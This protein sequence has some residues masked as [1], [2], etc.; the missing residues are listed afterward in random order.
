MKKVLIGGFM[1]LIGF[2]SVILA[3]SF[4]D[5]KNLPFHE[6]AKLLVS[7]MT[8]EE[9]SNQLKNNVGAITRLGVRNYNY[10]NEGIHG[11]A[12]SGEA[13]S[14]P[15]S[16]GLSS[17]WDADL[18][19]RVASAISDEAR[20][21]NN[22]TGKGLTYW[23]PT[24]NLS[25][26]PRWGRDEE[27]YGE[28]P[29]LTGTLAV[30]F[31]KGL[32]GDHE[33]YYKTIATAKH[34]AAN[35]MEHERSSTSSNMDERNLREYYLPAF[36][37]CVKDGNVASIMSAYNALNGIPCIANK[38]LLTKILRDEWG[39]DGFVTS[40]C[41]GV[42][43]LYTDHKYATDAV[44]AITKAIKAGNDMNCNGD[45]AKNV[46]QAINENRLTEADI[47]TALVR[48][49][50]SRFR[51]GEFDDDVPYRN[52][53]ASVLN[54]EQHRQLAIDAAHESIVLLK[55]AETD[56]DN[57]PLLPL[58]PD[59][60]V[61]LIGPFA[62]Y[63]NLGGYSGTPV[64]KTSLYQALANRFGV[65]ISDN[66]LQ[67]EKY[68]EKQGNM[69]AEANGC[70]GN[71]GN[72]KAGDWAKYNSVDLGDGCEILTVMTATANSADKA[73]IMNIYLDNMDGQP[74][75]TVDLPA[76]GGWT[77]YKES[78][79]KLNP[80][81]FKGKHTV[82]FEFLGGG[83]FCSNMD[84]FRFGNIEVEYVKATSFMA[85]DFDG[86]KGNAK[87]E[88]AK[89]DGNIT[90]LGNIK[91]G[92]I[93]WF[94]NVNFSYGFDKL[95]FEFATKN[96]KKNAKI[97]F[98]FDDLDSEPVFTVTD[99]LV[100]CGSSGGWQDYI[101]IYKDLDPEVFKGIHTLYLRFYIE[102][103]TYFGNL[104]QILFYNSEDGDGPV[105]DDNNNDENQRL[106]YARC[107]NVNDD[108]GNDIALAQSLAKK[109]DVVIFTAGTDLSTMNEGHDRTTLKLPGGQ[110][111]VLEAIYE[112]NPN[113]ILVLQS[114]SSHDVTWA[115]EHIPAILSA[116]YAGQ[117]QGEAIADVIYGDFNPSGKLT[118]TWYGKDEDL[119][120]NIDDYDIRSRKLTYMYFDKE[121]LYPF[122]YGLSY[123]SFDYSNL[124]ISQSVIAKDETVTITF[125]VTN[126]GD[127]DGAEVVQL[128]THANS[129]L[130]RPIKELKGYE[131]VE[132]KSGETKSVTMTL[133]HD[134][135]SYFNTATKT[136]DV[137][138]GVVDIMVGASSSDIRL[139]D[140]LNTRF[141][142][143]KTTYESIPQEPSSSV[144]TVLT[145]EKAVTETAIYNI[146]GMKLS[147]K[148]LE[149]VSPGIY[150]VNGKKVTTSAKR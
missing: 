125:D 40:D 135:L 102:D 97:E 110:Q 8:L 27:N 95:E 42:G 35:N 15:I 11:V 33:K 28:D 30:Q 16:K 70:D 99:D 100:F 10:W 141:A 67:F 44:D 140:K 88:D 87:A 47:D 118:S 76:T 38:L 36:E 83:T 92:D 79:F 21:Y 2:S 138:E 105:V 115:N 108:R 126:T 117:A 63:V 68:D 94:E 84:W 81:I 26:D 130:D 86:K 90:N 75:L 112:V 62:N 129:K 66:N 127:M 143:V 48:I 148:S 54:C 82:Y 41:G 124:E 145:D 34:F 120:G 111:K 119:K 57:H 20:V 150:I 39:F 58:A 134:Q 103:A 101:T 13:T 31:I 147:A 37:M 122:G 22:T 116:W 78:T 71:L 25:R 109:A 121:P 51:L 32:Q 23:C 65:D 89:K 1:C 77:S 144:D 53:P 128:Y 61:A 131:R 85:Y 14:F 64:Y 106:F 73:T 137:E 19:Y 80:D 114:A 17:M 24:I 93:V 43:Y 3:Q 133:S 74:D 98:Y 104:K 149:N 69:A 46:I 55:N 56:N 49:F 107:C 96:C 45:F 29:Y 6:R 4:Q 60:K 5:N 50:E 91:N 9:K 18:M 123:T 146:N 113:V 72:V 59:K 132:L 139:S 136:F 12:R 52:I 142:V 7:Q